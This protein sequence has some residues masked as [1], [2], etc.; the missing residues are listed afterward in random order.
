MLLREAYRVGIHPDEFWRMSYAEL[1]A[2]VAGHADTMMD[3]SRLAAWSVAMIINVWVAPN[4]R[5]TPAEL[6]GDRKPASFS[7]MD[8]YRERMRARQRKARMEDV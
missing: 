2:C 5:V 3:L 4:D 1:M 6:L 7:D 8:D